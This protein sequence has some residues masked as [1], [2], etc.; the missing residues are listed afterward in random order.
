MSETQLSIPGIPPRYFPWAARTDDIIHRA[1]QSVGE[2]ADDIKGPCRQPHIVRA[3]WAV[4]LALREA[5]WSTPRIGRA[6]NNRDHTTV[7]HGLLKGAELRATDSK[8][9]AVCDWVAG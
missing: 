8:F 2:K 5:G 3:R 1:A 7:R 6:L 4:M 9:A